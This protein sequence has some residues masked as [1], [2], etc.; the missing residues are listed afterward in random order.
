MC[1]PDNHTDGEG[2]LFFYIYEEVK[3]TIDVA[4]WWEHTKILDT[5]NTRCEVILTYQSPYYGNNF[6]HT[7]TAFLLKKAPDFFKEWVSWAPDVKLW[8]DSLIATVNFTH[9]LHLCQTLCQSFNVFFAHHSF[10][11]TPPFPCPSSC[12][13]LLKM[14][15]KK[16]YD[17]W[18]VHLLNR[19][20]IVNRVSDGV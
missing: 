15:T 19:V 16:I 13:I 9:Y 20:L 7:T 4:I 11:V 8:Y 1:E 14:N 10:R 5:Q 18:C 17:C 6:C 2:W 3:G 12:F